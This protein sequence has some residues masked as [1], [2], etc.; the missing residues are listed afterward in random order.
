MNFLGSFPYNKSNFFLSIETII[1]ALTY[2]F[3]EAFFPI[4]L[5]IELKT[6][7]A[8]LVPCT[9]SL[10]RVSTIPIWKSF[11]MRRSIILPFL[12]ATEN[13][14]KYYRMSRL[15]S[16]FWH[17]AYYTINADKICVERKKRKTSRSGRNTYNCNRWD[18]PTASSYHFC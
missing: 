8:S 14:S 2:T 9:A 4:A 1:A 3:V 12:P 17:Q 5:A 18:Q 15:V 13:G 7:L 11:K 16:P 6:S 10:T